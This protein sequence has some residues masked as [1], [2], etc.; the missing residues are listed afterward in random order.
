LL[1]NKI[2]GQ[3]AGGVKRA[4][5]PASAD[6]SRAKWA[7][8]GASWQAIGRVSPS[9][10]EG[11]A[12]CHRTVANTERA[13]PMSGHLVSRLSGICRAAFQSGALPPLCRDA[14]ASAP[15]RHPIADS[16]MSSRWV[17]HPLT[18]LVNCVDRKFQISLAR[19]HPCVGDH[20]RTKAVVSW[21][22]LSHGPQLSKPNDPIS[23][24]LRSPHMLCRNVCLEDA[25]ILLNHILLSQG[26][27]AA[28]SAV[29][30][31]LSIQETEL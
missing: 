31:G 17:V 29:Q 15:G 30:K 10:R 16:H 8:G 25:D 20:A 5:G 28:I 2:I 14:P 9:G 21:P 27:N 7:I 22:R 18:Y 19:V 1:S 24:T 4:G 13:P 12:R 6:A 26:R 3:A 11:R 23:S